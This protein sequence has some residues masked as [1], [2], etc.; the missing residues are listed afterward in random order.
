MGYAKLKEITEFTISNCEGKVYKRWD[1]VLKKM[2]TSDVWI[3]DYELKYTFNTDKGLLDLSQGQLG[4]I[5]ACAYSQV[6]GASQIN[7]KTFT[8]KTNG[9]TGIDIRYYF[10]MNYKQ[11]DGYRAVKTEEQ[12]TYDKEAFNK[13]VEAGRQEAQMN[14]FSSEF[15]GEQINVEELPF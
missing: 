6:T 4:Q 12:A 3:K 13:A 2:E 10:G 15:G 7:G 1:S 8:V 9:K 11:A 5:L 14:E